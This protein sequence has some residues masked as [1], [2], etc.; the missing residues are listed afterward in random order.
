MLLELQEKN[1]ERTNIT[2]PTSRKKD[3]KT[4]LIKDTWW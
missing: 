1:G 2:R 4:K 3:N